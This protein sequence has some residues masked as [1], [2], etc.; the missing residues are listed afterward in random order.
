MQNDTAISPC[1]GLCNHYLHTTNNVLP[2]K[3]I[4]KYE[5][6]IKKEDF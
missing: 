5:I 3:P 4:Q 1:I 6:S 2:I